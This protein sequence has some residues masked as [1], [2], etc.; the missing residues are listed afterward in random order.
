MSQRLGKVGYF[1]YQTIDAHNRV[2]MPSSRSTCPF[3]WVRAAR[4]NKTRMRRKKDTFM[5]DNG[6]K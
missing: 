2:L 4:P 1:T 5:A 6:G 3:H